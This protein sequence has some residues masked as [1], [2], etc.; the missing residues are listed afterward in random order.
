MSEKK[1]TQ[2]NRIAN[3]LVVKYT[4]PNGIEKWL[5]AKLIDKENGIYVGPVNRSTRT[6]PDPTRK[7]W[8]RGT[9]EDLHGIVPEYGRKADAM[10]KAGDYFDMEVEGKEIS[11]EG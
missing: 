11:D 3:R 7:T 4:Y 10:R 9:L 1:Q 8:V 2:Y 5:V 6:K